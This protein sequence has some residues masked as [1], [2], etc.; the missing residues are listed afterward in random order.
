MTLKAGIWY[1]A[2]LAPKQT[3]GF[4]PVDALSVRILTNTKTNEITGGE[5]TQQ[6]MYPLNQLKTLVS[7]G[8]DPARSLPLRR[9][10][11]LIPLILVS[12]ALSPNAQAAPA[13][14]TPDPGSV[15][16]GV[17]NTADGHNALFSA[18]AAS[19]G[20]SAFGGFSL[21]ALT[22]GTFN[23]GVGVLALDLNNADFNT[24]VGAAALLFNNTGV[25]ADTGTQNTAVGTAALESNVGG[26]ND[27]DGSFNDAVGAFALVLNTTGSSNNAFGNSAL[28]NNQVAAANTAIGD[29][30][31]A[32]NDSTG[33]GLGN[34]NVAV[35]AGALF[36]NTDGDSNNAVGFNAMGANADGLFN[37]AVGFDA[38][39]DNVSGAGNVAVGDSAGAGVEGDFNIYI[40]AFAGPAPSPAPVAESE[41]IRIGD[42]FNI[43]TFIG[44]I[45]GVPVTGV[46]VCVNGDGQ[47]GECG[48]ASSPMSANELH[49][50]QGVVQE[51]KATTERQAAV[52]ALQE[53]QIKALTAGLKQQADQ[54]QK[55][56]AQLEMIRPTPR[57]VENR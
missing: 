43:A 1:H 2:P 31:L 56:S 54:I 6:S 14:Q 37:N 50:Q 16:L 36:S 45:S 23:T 44:G 53:G 51:L 24:A 42:A 27:G 9:G 15:P 13:P 55:V 25:G 47:L 7:C 39:A 3:K 48:P 19:V 38:L 33:A 8:R 4:Y 29:V 57:V 10:F 18:T 32:N 22:T 30:A 5:R 49:K 12:F 40:G 20:N 28:F 34:A 41:T 26:A 35:G 52:I 21:F 46:P 17:L 11:L